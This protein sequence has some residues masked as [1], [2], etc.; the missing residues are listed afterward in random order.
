MVSINRIRA[1]RWTIGA[2]VAVVLFGIAG[3]LGLPAAT[4]WGIETV[5]SR[6][7][8]RPLTVGKISANPFTLHI[9]AHDLTRCA[10]DRRPARPHRPQPAAALQLQ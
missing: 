1:R 2:L 4:R 9:T 8:G 5:A 10:A 3:A 7:L 6:E